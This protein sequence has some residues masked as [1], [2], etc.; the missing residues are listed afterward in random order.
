MSNRFTAAIRDTVVPPPGAGRIAASALADSLGSGL[1]MSG[2]VVYFSLRLKLDT[3]AIG[4]GFAVA[5]VVALVLVT[6][7][8]ALA[9]RVG[10]A[11]TLRVAHFARTAIYPLYP[12]AGDTAAFV[13]ILTAVTIADRV[14][15]PVFQA[16]VGVAVGDDRRSETMGYVRALR[17]AG[18]SLG[19]LAASLALV[20]GTAQ[21]YDAIPIGNAVSFALAGLLLGGIRNTRAPRTDRPKRQLVGVRPRYLVLGLLNV[22]MLLHDTMLLLALPLFVLG[23]TTVPASVLPLMFALNTVL[24]VVLQR[25]L[26]RVAATMRGAARAEL[27]AGWLLAATCLCLAAAALLPGAGAVVVLV[28]AVV[29]LTLG[30][31]LQVAGAWELSHSHAPEAD[32]GRYLAAFSIGIGLQRSLGPV[33][34]SAFA[35][36]GAVTWLPV[37]ALFVLAGGA[38]KRLAGAP[39]PA[40]ASS[41]VR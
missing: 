27:I 20:I 9:D 30:E 29:L 37:A 39:W 38:T 28:V 16:M 17:N 15:A 3:V 36:F 41:G 35:V 25:R 31:S 14:A 23:H 5:G 34:V 40:R 13:A 32:R 19:A 8:G 2:A 24:V 33:V 11:R 4:A 1:F 26:S 6:P 12:L 10:Y 22:V 18:F 21:A 7:L